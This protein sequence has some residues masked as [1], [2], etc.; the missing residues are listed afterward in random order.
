M[1]SIIFAED[2]DDVKRNALAMLKGERPSPYEF[3]IVTKQNKICWVMETVQSM[4]FKGK[5][6]ILGNFIN[7][8]ERKAVENRLQ[9][10]EKL[11]R[12]IVETTG[13]ATMISEDDMTISLLNSP[14]EKMT[15]YRREEWE[16]KKKWTEYIAKK[17]RPRMMK[18]H[19]LRRLD[20]AAAPKQFEHD[21]IDSKG[22]IRRMFLTVDLIPGTKK[23]IG[24][25]VDITEWKEAERALKKREQEL[26]IKSDNLAELN[27]ALRVLLKQ[28]ENDREELEDQVLSNVKELVIPYIEKVQKCR[29]DAKAMA[30]IEILESNLNDII[31][32]FSR[33]LSSKYMN[34]TPRE[35]QIANFVKEGKTS[36]EIADIFN[37]SKSAVDI[38]RHRLRNKLGLKNK[39]LNLR[40]HLTIFS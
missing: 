39:R 28:R 31:S 30:Y 20:P 22:R 3:R 37:V 16:G 11:Y 25:F 6:A 5:M 4:L 35:L 8:T 34:L 7:I 36:K 23:S 15:G 21:L 9:E 27:T 40:S 14:F 18:T 29:L 12:I 38:H 19:R 1:D 2:K 33:K 10:S 13:A 17:D 24:S 26:R 32:P